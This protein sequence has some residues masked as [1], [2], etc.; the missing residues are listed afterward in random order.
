K[1][2]GGNEMNVGANKEERKRQRQIL[3]R[4]YSDYNPIR[5]DVFVCR[6]NS[7]R[8]ADAIRQYMEARGI[9]RRR[10]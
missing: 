3:Q 2:E 1:K 10:D 5:H 9:E 4:L 8:E 6:F 7:E